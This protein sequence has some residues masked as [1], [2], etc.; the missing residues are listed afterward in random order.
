MTWAH[1]IHEPAPSL[2][3]EYTRLERR[4]RAKG[5]HLRA[6]VVLVLCGAR[7]FTSG[8]HASFAA[9]L[10][11]LQLVHK[12]IWTR[13]DIARWLRRLC[14]PLS[15]SPPVHTE[16]RRE[17]YIQ[18]DSERGIGC[19]APSPCKLACSS[20]EFGSREQPPYRSRLNCVTGGCVA[21]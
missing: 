14:P 17:T 21:G 11:H 19:S 6:G 20:W 9:A 7:R 2:V 15:P 4:V 13:K 10:S 1:S 12:R 16:T 5:C 18:R 3:T 8:T